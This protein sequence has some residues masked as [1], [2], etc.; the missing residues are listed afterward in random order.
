MLQECNITIPEPVSIFG[1]KGYFDTPLKDGSGELRVMVQKELVD[2]GVPIVFNTAT[3]NDVTG[4]HKPGQMGL[5]AHLLDACKVDGERYR[6]VQYVPG[7]V[8]ANQEL[9]AALIPK[10]ATME[11]VNAAKKLNTMV[12][13]FKIGSAACGAVKAALKQPR[14]RRKNRTGCNLCYPLFYFS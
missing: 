9:Y 1:D 5:Q 6:I 4:F 10:R 12:P 7:G 8:R 2:G 11:E 13:V 3:A 14:Q